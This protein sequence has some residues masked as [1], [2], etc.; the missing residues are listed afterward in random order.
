MES[1]SSFIRWWRAIDQGTHLIDLTLLFLG[2]VILKHGFAHTYFWNMDVDDNVFLT[3]STH[4]NKIAFLHA[5]CT[6]W[7][8]LFSFEI[9]C[10]MG[11]LNYL[12]L[13]EAM[14]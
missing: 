13:V 14:V 7:K 11:K 2:D 9:F 4:S 6:E 5:S 1:K 10:R 8:N 12:V 3:L